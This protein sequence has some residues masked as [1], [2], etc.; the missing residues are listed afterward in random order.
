MKHI[1]PLVKFK[2][3]NKEL[4]NFLLNDCHSHCKK[5]ED[6]EIY[7]FMCFSNTIK[8]TELMGY[9]SFYFNSKGSHNNKVLKVLIGQITVIAWYYEVEDFGDNIGANIIKLHS[10]D[11]NVYCKAA[12]KDIINNFVYYY[13]NPLELDKW[14]NFLKEKKQ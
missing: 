9:P 13:Q 8:L 10:K 5:S 7:S 1:R 6:N 2:K 11:N 3:E 14:Y 12:A 4:V